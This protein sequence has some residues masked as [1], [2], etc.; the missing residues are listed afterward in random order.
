M[1][2]AQDFEAEMK[3]RDGELSALSQA[4]KVISEMTS[5]AEDI[6]YSAVQTPSLLQHDSKLSTGEDLANFEAVRF[7]RKLAKEFNDPALAQLAS[8]QAEMDAIR[9][10]EKQIFLSNQADLQQGLQ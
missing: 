1:E 6:T 5:G 3:S 7:V 8:R 9:Q 2:A 4:K 10:K